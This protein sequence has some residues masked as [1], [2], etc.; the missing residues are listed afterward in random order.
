[1]SAALQKG[2]FEEEAN[3]NLDA[4][5]SNYQSL[6]TQ[7]DRDR[8]IAATAIFRLGECY[9]KLGQDNDAVVQYQRILR[10]FPDQ[11]TLATLSRQNLTALHVAVPPQLITAPQLP[12]PAG[13]FQQRL[14]RIIAKVPQDSVAPTAAE[15]AAQAAGLEAEA[16]SLKAQIAHLSGL[17][18]EDRRT[19]IQQNFSNPVLTTL[20]QQLNEAEQNLA[21]LTNDYTPTDLHVARV[22]AQLNAINGQIDA[23]VGGVIKGL[24]SKMEADLDAAKT[25]RA[26]AGSAPSARPA[27][28]TDDEA[29]EI[30]RI[31]QMIQ[32]SPDLINAERG[33]DAPL[34]AA[35]GKGQL[36]VAGFLLDHGA[37]IE[38]VNH[39]VPLL[40]AARNGNRAMVELLLGRGADVNAKENDGNNALHYAAGRGFQAVAEVLLANHA[41]VNIPNAGGSTPLFSAASSG[42][43]KIIQMLLAAGANTNLK[44]GKGRSPLNYAIGNAPEIFQALLDAG[45]NPNT[46]DSEGRTPLS[47]AGERDSSKVVRLLL[48]AK[49][50]PNAG[51]LDVPLLCAIHKQDVG[52]A[53]LLL[54]NGANPNLKGRMDWP[55]T[56]GVQMYSGANSQDRPGVTPLYLAVSTGQLPVVNLLLKF[57][58]DPNDSQSDGRPLLFSALSDPDIL[59]ALLDAGGKVDSHFSGGMTLLDQAVDGYPPRAAVEILLKHG[60]DPSARDLRGNTPLH[61]AAW[62]APDRNKIELLLDHHADPNVRGDD[63]KTPLDYIKGRLAQSNIA[64]GDKASLSEIAGLLRQHGALDDLPDWYRITVSRPSVKFSRTAFPKGTNDWNRFTLLELVAVQCQ[65]L[66][67]DSKDFGENDDAQ[68]FFQPRNQPL[69]FPDLT[70]LR[71]RRPAA[72]LKSWKEQTVDLGS[73]LKSGDCTKDLSLEWGDVVEIPETDHPLNESWPGFSTMELANLKKC[74]TR[75]VE[76]IVKGQ[77]NTIAL[78]PGISI[79]EGEDKES[80]ITTII[81]KVPFWLR[82]VLLQSKLVL[83]SCDLSRVKV[84]RTDPAIGKKREWIADCSDPNNVP[85]LWLRDGDVI[86]V[87]EKP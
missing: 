87:P 42:Q 77:T 29:K 2:L 34:Y 53:E 7:F 45:T 59:G 38:G 18:R 72:D 41:D 48:A 78:A 47:Y 71:I 23:Q 54:A 28:V 24:Q 35:A 8:Q 10:E 68:V 62:G 84:T 12:A 21:S 63:G 5:I 40:A 36:R 75:H 67:A 44:D 31:Q 15:P 51:K 22:T 32:N 13:T 17:N 61:Y 74:L 82:P 64:S 11:P 9:R 58:A 39:H 6:A 33:D 25:L 69:P 73:G 3:R 46:E 86:E 70:H 57:K 76:I 60:A 83:S 19:A 1:L 27:D 26:Q 49:A 16:A 55:V 80:T 4:A 85:D 37:N 81:S 20:M 66:A 30:Q 50:D 43:L 14:Q 65:F 56:L 79:V 52:S